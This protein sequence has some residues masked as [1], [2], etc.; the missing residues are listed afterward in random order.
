M[1]MSPALK[2]LRYRTGMRVGIHG[3]PAG[4]EAEVAAAEGITRAPARA[5]DLDIVQAFFTRKTHLERSLARLEASRAPK[6]ILWICYPKA[7][8]LGTDLHR[9]T[10]RDVIARAG[11]QAVAIVAIDAV[12]SAL[13]VKP[14]G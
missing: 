7:K 6:G 11:L 10:I 9:D 4:F 2:K 14:V 12:W 3:A 5:K 1:T 8:G 13:R